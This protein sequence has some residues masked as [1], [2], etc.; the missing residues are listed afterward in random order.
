MRISSAWL[1]AAVVAVLLAVALTALLPGGGET[2][3]EAQPGPIPQSP[4]PAPD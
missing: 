2:T 4:A 1:I 3:G